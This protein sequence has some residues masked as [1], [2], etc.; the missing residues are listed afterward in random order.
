SSFWLSWALH[1]N[2]LHPHHIFVRRSWLRKFAN[3]FSLPDYRT[4]ARSLAANGSA[5]RHVRYFTDRGFH[6]RLAMS[7]G[8]CRHAAARLAATLLLSIIP[9][10][11][12]R[13]NLLFVAGDSRFSI[14]QLRFT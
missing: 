2:D 1:I 6:Y 3:A 12:R 14:Y 11:G 13:S 7:G 10:P 4:I 9:G 5:R 8:S